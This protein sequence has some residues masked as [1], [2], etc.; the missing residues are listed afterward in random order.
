MPRPSLIRASASTIPTNGRWVGTWWPPAPPTRTRLTIGR[1]S[2]ALR[3]A[4]MERKRDAGGG[5]F[6]I[7]LVET[8]CPDFAA[9]HPGQREQQAASIDPDMIAVSPHTLLYIDYR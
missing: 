9:L 5:P 3:V 2:N 1:G 8:T 7:R 4:G 6:A